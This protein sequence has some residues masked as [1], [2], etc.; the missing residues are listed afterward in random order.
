MGSMKL[1]IAYVQRFCNDTV[2]VYDMLN[3]QTNKKVL[4]Y[5]TLYTA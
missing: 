1:F 5:R 4:G 2:K 3:K